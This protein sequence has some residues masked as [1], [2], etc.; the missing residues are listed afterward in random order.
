LE[1]ENASSEKAS[2]RQAAQNRDGEIEDH[3]A[4]DDEARTRAAAGQLNH[5]GRSGDSVG[6]PRTQKGILHF[7]RCRIFM[8][9][10]KRIAA[11]G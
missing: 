7:A 3:G 8:G 2:R 4:Q 11:R 6:S 10:A 9:R 1:T 5:A